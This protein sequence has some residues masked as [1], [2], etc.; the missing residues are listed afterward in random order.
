[1][2]YIA[3]YKTS[4]QISP[5]D[6]DTKYRVLELNENTTVRTIM[7]WVK[8]KERT[9]DFDIKIIKVNEPSRL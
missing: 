2:K 3:Q 7:E 8:E 4:F 5:D 6:W 1:M 9:D